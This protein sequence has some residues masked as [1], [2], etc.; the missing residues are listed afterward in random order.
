[1][2]NEAN[3]RV[4]QILY[5]W[6]EHNLLGER[7][8]GPIA[9]SLE[10]DTD[11]RTVDS[12]LSKYVRS[13]DTHDTSRPE[14]S[15][16][17]IRTVNWAAI[18]HRARNEQFDRHDVGHAL[19]GHPASFG[20]TLALALAHW[21][22]WLTDHADGQR[23]PILTGRELMEFLAARTDTLDERCA[24]H[25]V[26][27]TTTL[28]ARLAAYTGKLGVIV[29]DQVSPDDTASML[30]GCQRVFSALTEGLGT[31]VRVLDTFTTYAPGLTDVAYEALN[32][33]CA[34]GPGSPGSF[35]LVRTVA[36]PY[37]NPARHDAVA[38]M[39]AE[40]YFDGG[41]ARLRDFLSSHGV[42]AESALAARMELL[43]RLAQRR[44][45]PVPEPPVEHGEPQAREEP[46]VI[47]P[48]PAPPRPGPPTPRP[49][50]GPI[51][52][53][54][55]GEA[56][57]RVIDLAAR[58]PQDLAN[59]LH[60]F[61]FF[62]EQLD[63]EDRE[64][65]RRHLTACCFHAG[66]L[67]R[68]PHERR[69]EVLAALVAAAIGPEPESLDG[70]DWRSLLDVSA[71]DEVVL[72]ICDYAATHE[73]W[74]PLLAWLELRY[75]RRTGYPGAGGWRRPV[76]ALSPAL[77]VMLLVGLTIGIALG[78]WITT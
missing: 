43:T 38:A 66:R 53:P 75:L 13:A 62:A 11:L 56:L 57:E 31:A 50:P 10:T 64:R 69:H 20:P 77:G 39:L 36:R 15:M 51:P 49:A 30:W 7:G 68:L 34:P 1:M 60:E 47:R 59:G 12:G 5:S 25:A 72:A 9:S 2:P 52:A 3:D 14:W 22:G 32:L 73:V 44:A 28:S 8:Y 40:T 65:L 61:R 46:P 27:M 71:P 48:E 55:G 41:A 26:P 19:I 4:F 33:V 76:Q 18:L 23:V 42:Y 54:P 35:E 58:D 70:P 78:A 67:R 21:P 6:T 63:E 29:P 16:C 37:A 74:T 45:V 24:A 17:F